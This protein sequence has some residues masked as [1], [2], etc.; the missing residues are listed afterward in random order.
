MATWLPYVLGAIFLGL[1]FWTGSLYQQLKSLKTG[2]DAQVPAQ[3]DE[4]LWQ[5]VLADPAATL[6]EAEAPVTIVEFLD[7]QCPYCQQAFQETIP[8]IK[9][10][11]IDSGQARLL[12]HD[13]PLSGHFNARVAALAA[14]CA[15][16]QD[17]YFEMHD[18]LFEAQRDWDLGSPSQ[19]FKT[20]ARS[21]GLNA[22]Q[23]NSCY[24]TGKYEQA[25]EADLNLAARVGASKTPTFFINQTILIGAQEFVEF[26]KVIERELDQ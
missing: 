6:G 14:R 1:V 11:Y 4:T 20:F 18:K 9:S 2:G 10:R 12:V 25:I 8:Q 21:L 22:N 7:F 26:E 13:L 16:E 15:G 24:D 17:K 5:E 19:M 23:F 3:I